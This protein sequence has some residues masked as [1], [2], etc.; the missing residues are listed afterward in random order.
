MFA[1]IFKRK[2]YVYLKGDKLK[3]K[4]KLLISLDV[5]LVKD[6]RNKI[7][8]KRNSLSEYFDRLVRNDIFS[9]SKKKRVKYK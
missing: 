1:N 3:K 6:I 4:E 5:D 8:A 7:P 2:I 9:K